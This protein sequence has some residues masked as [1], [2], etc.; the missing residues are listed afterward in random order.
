MFSYTRPVMSMFTPQYTLALQ[1]PND[2]LQGKPKNDVSLLKITISFWKLRQPFNNW[3]PVV[4]SL[5]IIFFFGGEKIEKCLKLDLFPRNS[6]AR[7]GRFFPFK[8]FCKA[9]PIVPGFSGDAIEAES[10][11]LSK[12]VS[13]DFLLVPC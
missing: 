5:S 6:Q 8:S 7:V 12:S 3:V 13:F 1:K 11:K 4:V 9:S 10:E 2:F